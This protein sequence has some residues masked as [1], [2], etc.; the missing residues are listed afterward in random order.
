MAVSDLQG[1][2]VPTPHVLWLLRR[3]PGASSGRVAHG[4]FFL[5]LLRRPLLLGLGDP[6]FPIMEQEAPMPGD[7]P[8]RY[9]AGPALTRLL[10]PGH[11]F[12]TPQPITRC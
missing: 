2:Y 10:A 8:H 7:R 9:P 3:S 1:D 5:G 4:S 11:L 6:L 12:L